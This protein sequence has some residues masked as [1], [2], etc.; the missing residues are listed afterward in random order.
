MEGLCKEGRG[1]GEG[2]HVLCVLG[3]TGV[4]VPLEVLAHSRYSL[5]MVLLCVC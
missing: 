2:F 3:L 5:G 1:Y 4:C